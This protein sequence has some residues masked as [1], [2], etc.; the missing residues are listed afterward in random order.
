M[1]GR[2]YLNGQRLAETPSG[3]SKFRNYLMKPIADQLEL[4]T[5]QME[6]RNTR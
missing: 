4:Q 1:T 5:I 2:F 6:G 3:N